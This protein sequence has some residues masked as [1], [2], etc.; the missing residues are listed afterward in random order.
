MTSR[1]IE[2][3]RDRFSEAEIALKKYERIGL[4]T[5]SS[6][7]NELRYAG[8]HILAAD[9]TAVEEEIS[10]H[11]Y[12]AERHCARAK[13]D[14]KE[15]TVLALLKWMAHYR[16]LGLTAEELCEFVP[17]WKTLLAT[18][19][20][21][22][23]LL[24]QCGHAKDIDEESLD[25]AIADLISAREKMI[26]AEPD[27]LSA[28]EKKFAKI[29][30]EKQ[31]AADESRAAEIRVAECRRIL[32]DRRYWRSMSIAWL[33]IVIGILGLAGTAYGV[34]LTLRSMQ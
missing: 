5:L 25:V 18:A 32:E 21:S 13:F 15:S 28:R 8:Q 6:V 26:A 34:L 9:A 14:A 16:S 11:L 19:E 33:G 10:E 27:I 29:G 22:R 1:R 31:A 3:I 2:D 24:E 30:E 20:K 4:S 23:S 17:D 12:K 7:L